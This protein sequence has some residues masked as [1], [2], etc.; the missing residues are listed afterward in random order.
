MASSGGGRRRERA[1]MRSTT[2]LM[3]RAITLANQTSTGRRTKRRTEMRR[4]TGSGKSERVE[5]GVG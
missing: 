3:S 1:V 2:S 4:K 5:E